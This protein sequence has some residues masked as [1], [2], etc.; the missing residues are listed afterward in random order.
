MASVATAQD[1]AIKRRPGSIIRRRFTVTLYECMAGRAD[2]NNRLTIGDELPNYVHLRFWR[3]TSPDTKQRHISIVQHFDARQL[4]TV[5][6]RP[7]DERYFEFAT[8][9]LACECG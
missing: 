7:R 4:V 5:S 2:A 8:K 6:L 1:L 9:M 3:R